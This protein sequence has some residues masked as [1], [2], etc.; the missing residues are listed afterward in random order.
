VFP[1][2]GG[3]T[4]VFVVDVT[5]GTAARDLC[6]ELRRAG[7]AT[8]RAFDGRSMKAQ[9]KQADRSGAALAVIIGEDEAAAGSATVR[10]LRGEAGQAALARTDLVEHLQHLLGRA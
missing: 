7:L 3:R 9:M 6:F 5:G 8:D 10:D 1:A 4:D 2:P